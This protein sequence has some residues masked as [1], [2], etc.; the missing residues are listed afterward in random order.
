MGDH[1]QIATGRTPLHESACV[2]GLGVGSGRSP[3]EG[4]TGRPTGQVTV[5]YRGTGGELVFR[6]RLAGRGNVVLGC[7]GEVRVARHGAVMG[8][9]VAAKVLVHAWAAGT[10]GDDVVRLARVESAQRAVEV[11]RVAFVDGAGVIRPDRCAPRVGH[12]RG[13][14]S[15]TRQCPT[16]SGYARVSTHNPRT[17]SEWLTIS[18][19]EDLSDTPTGRLYLVRRGIWH[20][21]AGARARCARPTRRPAWPARPPTATW[22]PQRA[23][24]HKDASPTGKP[25][26]RR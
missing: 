12:G 20:R 11:V 21:S 24:D 5:G 23:V 3:A 1:C 6:R 7:S 8:D 17:S 16:A 26:A 18:L 4:A 13:R 19:P 22:T 2:W 15:S 25:P 14:S 9:C 10:H